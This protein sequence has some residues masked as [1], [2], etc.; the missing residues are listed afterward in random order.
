VNAEVILYADSVTDSMSKAMAET[1]RRREIQLAYNQEHNIT[2]RT[3]ISAI[4]SVIEDEV[5]AHQLAQEVVGNTAEDYV[6][7]E[8]LEELHK[9][10]LTAAEELDFER[11]AKL[12]DQYFKSKSEF[13]K[14]ELDKAKGKGDPKRVEELEAEI[15]KLQENEVVPEQTK[16]K[17][18]APKRK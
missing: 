5:A 4:K 11:A 17:K 18:K 15:A 6:T 14:N 10:M 12:R 3:V 2:P 8:F 13:L 16:K 1:A 9:E 7:A